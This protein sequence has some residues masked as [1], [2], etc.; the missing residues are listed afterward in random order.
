[1]PSYKMPS[2]PEDCDRLKRI[3]QTAPRGSETARRY[4]RLYHE[5]IDRK[6]GKGSLRESNNWA[7][8]RPQNWEGPSP[9]NNVEG[10]SRKTRKNRRK[11]RR[12]SRK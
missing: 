12:N 2:M 4:F 3:S 5:C 10:G 7:G 11:S 1:M 8:M 9:V 6:Y